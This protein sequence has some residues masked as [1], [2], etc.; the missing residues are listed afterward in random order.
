M[1]D[2][3]RIGLGLKVL[4]IKNGLTL[5]QAAAGLKIHQNT[6]CRYEKDAKK[7]DLLVFDKMLK[8]YNVEPIIF[9]EEYGANLHERK[10]G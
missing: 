4:R 9:F 3:K 2:S 5:K 10:E 8:F 7:I 6:L 1:L